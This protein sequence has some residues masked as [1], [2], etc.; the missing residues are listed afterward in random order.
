ML[1]EQENDILTRVGPGTPTGELLRR[2]WHPIAPAS[3]LTAHNPKKRIR[4][5]GEDLVLFRDR[6]GRLGLVQEHCPHRG[7]SFYYGFVEDDGIRC[8][9]HGWKFDCGGQCLDMPFEP[10]NAPLKS[11]VRAKA[12]PVEELSGLLFA[13]LGPDPAPL[14]PRYEPLVRRDVRRKIYILPM[15]ECNWLQVMENSVDPTHTHY[16]HGANMAARGSDEASFHYRKIEAIDFVV[17]KEANWGGIVKKRVFGDVDIASNE[18]HPVIFPTILLLPP[19][20]H[21]MMHFRVPVDDT[22]TQIFRCQFTPTEDSREVQQSE[23][24]V[25]HV[26]P[27]VGE[28]GEYHLTTF[29]SQDA[30]AWE[31]QGAIANRSREILGASDRGIALY[32]RLLKEQ[33]AILEKG[34]DP[35]GVIRD[36]ALNGSISIALSPQQQEFRKQRLDGAKAEA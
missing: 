7:V 1:S 34:G 23:I 8:A 14:L 27:F 26:K 18:G 31:T 9:Y 3:T 30:M 20:P 24:P 4:I 25:E 5:L 13:Y 33:L 12:Y 29:G 15:L 16:L 10:E 2:Y 11:K 36:P 32:R 21:V 6:S 17:R 35:L 22:H 19:H 28:D